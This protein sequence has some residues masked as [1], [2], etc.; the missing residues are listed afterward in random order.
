[1][2]CAIQLLRLYLKGTLVT[3][4][5]DHEAL[6]WLLKMPNASENLTRWPMR[7]C[8]SHF[9]FVHCADF[10]HQVTSAVTDLLKMKIMKYC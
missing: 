2:M 3:I 6:E 8:K 10:R 7:L 1:M 5:I 9:Q 4:R